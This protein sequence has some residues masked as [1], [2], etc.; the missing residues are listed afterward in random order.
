[1]D[2][3]KTQNADLQ[4][5]Q[6]KLHGGLWMRCRRPQISSRELL[7]KCN[8]GERKEERSSAMA[9]HLVEV[10]ESL[11]AALASVLNAGQ[12]SVLQVGAVLLVDQLLQQLDAQ[13]QRRQANFTA[14]KHAS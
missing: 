10:S 14:C 7:S 1:M 12:V 4:F 3:H 5:L 13:L 2:S 11:S 6:E 8:A 9:T